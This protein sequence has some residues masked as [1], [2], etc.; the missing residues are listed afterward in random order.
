MTDGIVTNNNTLESDLVTETTGLQLESP[1]EAKRSKIWMA[2][3]TDDDYEAD[4]ADDVDDDVD[5]S[6]SILHYACL[7][8]NAGTLRQMIPVL[9]DIDPVD[10]FGRTPLHLAAQNGLGCCVDILIKAGANVNARML[11]G[12]TP[13]HLAAQNGHFLI[14]RSLERAGARAVRNDDGETPL[15]CATKNNHLCCV[16]DL[17]ASSKRG[18]KRNRGSDE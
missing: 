13:L 16:K 4:E 15:H 9:G 1:T 8:C 12:N 11:N 3:E 5:E 2:S 17:I 18:E 14:I 7:G 6:G 10:R